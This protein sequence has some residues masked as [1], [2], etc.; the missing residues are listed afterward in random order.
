MLYRI[1]NLV[2]KEL[3]QLARDRLL[4]PFVIL[5]PVTELVLVAYSTSVGIEHLPT[6]V[7]DMDHTGASRALVV[8]MANTRTFNISY[9][10]PD[11]GEVTAYLDN[12]SAA[13]ALII[14]PG[15]ADGLVDPERRL[16]QVQVILDGSEPAAAQAAQDSAQGVITAFG[17][18]WGRGTTPGQGEMSA[19]LDLSL[20]VWFNEEMRAANYT[21]PSE[22][23]FML[24]FVAVMVASLGIARE[25]ERGT[26]EQLLVTPLRPI[27]L[28][29][30][31]AV[32]AIIL[33]YVVFLMMLGIIVAGFHVPMR[34]SWPLLL[35]LALFYILVEL[36]WGIM[37][38]AVSRTQWQALLLVM[39]IVMVEMVFSGY[40]FPVELMP[41]PLR[42]LSN[43]APIKHWLLVFRSILLK[44]AGP[45][46]FW[47]ELLAL[48]VLGTGIL[49]MTI[50]VL[51]RQQLD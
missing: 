42:L 30:G 13:V 28:I 32:P 11:P 46:V 2:W 47:P 7:V 50:L 38:S 37:I 4:A 9:Y 25:R 3:I 29:I 19:P 17:Q 22:A 18:T 41:G 8:A 26:L 20:R 45:A 35:I 12:G 24:A 14:P 40:A 33:G 16:P 21:T 49:T 43:L 23:G 39:V 1:W 5:G 6:A 27:E 36:G 48:A 31:K 15:F 10:L 34:G 51:R 44:G